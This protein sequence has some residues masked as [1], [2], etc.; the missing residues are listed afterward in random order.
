MRPSII[1]YDND[2]TTG[3]FTWGF[4][5]LKHLQSSDKVHK[6]FKLGLCP[7]YEERRASEIWAENILAQ[8]ATRPV[9]EL[10][11]Q[12]V[13]VD[14]LSSLKEALDELFAE[15]DKLDDEIPRVYI[16]TVPEIW[17]DK[18][19]D[20]IHRKGPWSMGHIAEP[21]AAII[22]APGRMPVPGSPID[23]GS[24]QPSCR[25]VLLSIL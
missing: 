9:N 22:C 10:E 23:M 15:S 13:V 20:R 16:M 2:S 3:P 8:P 1:Q 6:W 18:E 5:A 24:D 21:E 14:Y 4:Q 11:A 19:K 12:K 17:N 25:M 7:E